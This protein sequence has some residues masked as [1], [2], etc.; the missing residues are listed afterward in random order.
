[1]LMGLSFRPGVGKMEGASEGYGLAGI[2][3]ENN[4]SVSRRIGGRIIKFRRIFTYGPSQRTPMGKLRAGRR[5][6][7]AGTATISDP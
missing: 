1:M 3:I 2:C 5:V 6:P 7:N 4:V